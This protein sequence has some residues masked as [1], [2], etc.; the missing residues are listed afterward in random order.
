MKLFISL[1]LTIH[2]FLLHAQWNYDSLTNTPVSTGLNKY[3]SHPAILSDGSGGYYVVWQQANGGTSINDL[4][5]Q[6]FNANGTPLWAANGIVICNLPSNQLW[7]SMVSDGS[8]GIIIIWQDNRTPNHHIYA[9]RVNA[10]GN[11]LWAANGVRLTDSFGEELGPVAV[12]DGAGGVIVGFWRIEIA[13]GE[14]NIIAQRIN[15]SGTIL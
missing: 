11:I 10:A 3:S 9:Q 8:G 4:Y 1:L 13:G 14:S 6:H 15:S 2:C 5:A 12:S 7:P